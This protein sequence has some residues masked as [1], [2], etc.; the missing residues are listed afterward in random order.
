MTGTTFRAV[1]GATALF[2]CLLT[3]ALPAVSATRARNTVVWRDVHDEVVLSTSGASAQELR[4][5]DDRKVD[6][7][8]L[9]SLTLQESTKVA[10]VGKNQS[11]TQ[12]AKTAE[13]LRLRHEY[14]EKRTQVIVRRRRQEFRR[15]ADI[16]RKRALRE[17]R[18]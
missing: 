6:Q 15:T 1:S 18:K 14:Q 2:I 5:R 16:E 17:V 4:A 7:A 11:M 3:S 13:I 10:S 9:D 8:R 12:E